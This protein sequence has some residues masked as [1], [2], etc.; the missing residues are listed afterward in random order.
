MS[1]EAIKW[2]LEE[3]DAPAPYKAVAVAIAWN[4]DKQGGGSWPSL[5][6]IAKRAGVGP[7]QARLLVRYMK[8]SGVIS[9]TPRP[10][11]TPVYT[12]PILAGPARV[13]P[14]TRTTPEAS[15]PGYQRPGSLTTEV[16]TD[17]G[18]IEQD[19]GYQSPDTPVASALRKV[20]EPSSEPSAPTLPLPGVSADLASPAPKVNSNG[21]RKVKSDPRP[22]PDSGGP[23]P[24]E[25]ANTSSSTSDPRGTR[26]PD[27]WP[28]TDELRAIA[29]SVDDRVDAVRQHAGFCDYWWAKAGRDARKANWVLTWRG[30]IRREADK[31]GPRPVAA[32]ELAPV[33]IVRTPEEIEAAMERMRARATRPGAKVAS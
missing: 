16:G 26:L 8:D 10:G 9:E 4:S 11:R 24:H 13:E 1:V 14:R 3:L 18:E 23:P 29:A 6:T 17:P 31:L 33:G 2:V 19:P 21:H 28:L 7:R 20:L 25:E 32:P 12:L 30:W 5:A 15:D 22:S 27:P